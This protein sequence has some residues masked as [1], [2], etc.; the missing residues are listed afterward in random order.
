MVQYLELDYH[1]NDNDD[2][3]H[4]NKTNHQS[5]KDALVL[6]NPEMLTNR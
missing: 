2:D 4:S 5:S 3:H 6:N 1:Y